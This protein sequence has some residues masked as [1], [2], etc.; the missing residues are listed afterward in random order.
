MLTTHVMDEAE[1]CD[2]LAMIR[3]GQLLAVDTPADLLQNTG[4]AS[5]EEAFL[6]YGG[7]RR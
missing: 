5:M 2:R 4:A 3:D 7:A 6:Y 1:K